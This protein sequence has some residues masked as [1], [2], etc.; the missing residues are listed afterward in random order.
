ME[1]IVPK[2]TSSVE[3][4]SAKAS[5]PN[6]YRFPAQGKDSDELIGWAVRPARKWIKNLS[7][8][9]QCLEL[10]MA[11]HL[12]KIH[13]PDAYLIVACFSLPMF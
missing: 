2:P 1:T 10:E 8:Q 13:T 9:S 6:R 5:L 4:L 3:K 12:G 7:L 11:K